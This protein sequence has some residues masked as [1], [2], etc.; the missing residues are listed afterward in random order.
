M[1]EMNGV[2]YIVSKS[3]ENSNYVPFQSITR[4]NYYYMVW[5]IE[6]EG[7]SDNKKSRVIMEMKID[8]SGLLNRANH[9][10]LSRRYLQGFE[11]LENYFKNSENQ[12]K[13][14]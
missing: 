14:K 3:I 2:Y 13:L 10:E 5:K 12:K 9:K 6:Q 7:H 11:N 8:H 1:F 4:G